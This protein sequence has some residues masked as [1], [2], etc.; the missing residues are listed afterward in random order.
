MKN[1]FIILAVGILMVCL[2]P[3]AVSAQQQEW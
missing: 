3:L 2:L 1:R